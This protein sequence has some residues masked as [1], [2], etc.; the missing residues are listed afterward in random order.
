MDE[1]ELKEY[2][3]RHLRRDDFR[4]L[5]MEGEEPR[6]YDPEELRKRIREKY[7]GLKKEQK[8]L[9]EKLIR[10]AGKEDPW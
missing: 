9:L 7:A 3:F 6:P 5:W 8:E 4:L 2:P 10:E 1:N